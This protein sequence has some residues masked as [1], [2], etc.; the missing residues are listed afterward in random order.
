MN[1]PT[2]A[3]SDA[4]S[5]LDLLDLRSPLAVAMAPFGTAQ[6][7][8]LSSVLIRGPWPNTAKTI[9][10]KELWDGRTTVVYAIRRMG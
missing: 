2:K 6:L 8:A 10:A 3:P 5:R 7:A 9:K 1:L 4:V